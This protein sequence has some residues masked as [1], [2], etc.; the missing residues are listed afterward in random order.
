MQD[1]KGNALFAFCILSKRD[2]IELS[3]ASGNL[4]GYI[5]LFLLILKKKEAAKCRQCVTNI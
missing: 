3:L 4:G 5:K 2:L 1:L